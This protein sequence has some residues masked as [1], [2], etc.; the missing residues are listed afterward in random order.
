MARSKRPNEPPMP[1]AVAYFLTWA[2]Y[3]TWLPGDERG[4]VWFRHGQQSPDLMKELEA[5][6]RMTE[7]AC[8]LDPEQRAL[9]EATIRKHCEIR[10]WALHAVNCRT[11]HLHVVVTS[12][13]H[14]D[15]VREQFKAWCTRNL[16]ELDLERNKTKPTSKGGSDNEW[17]RENWWAERG[18]RRF[19]GDEESLAAAVHYVRDGQ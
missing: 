2:T 14:P 15:V 18:S 10:G 7:S 9:V 19:I 1:E 13:R 16:K 12:N 3:G 8:R 4:W 6:S 17:V 11:N 5:A